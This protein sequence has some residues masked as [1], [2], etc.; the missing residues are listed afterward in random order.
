MTH[1]WTGSIF[2]PSAPTRVV[3]AAVI[4]AVGLYVLA[5]MIYLTVGETAAVQQ[6]WIG[7]G[8]RWLLA[9]GRLLGALAAMQE[10][11]AGSPL[12]A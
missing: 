7:A 8:S 3:I 12:L 2:A 6:L 5:T 4:V 1:V 9:C 10:S 11:R